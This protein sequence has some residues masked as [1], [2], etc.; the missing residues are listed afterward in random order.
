MIQ[1]RLQLLM[2]PDSRISIFS[3]AYLRY[4]NKKKNTKHNAPNRARVI[5]MM[6]QTGGLQDKKTHVYF[7]LN[8]SS[9]PLTEFV[10][11]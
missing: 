1:S 2:S 10:A 11:K 8:A 7:S 5:Q 3:L 9:H 6:R 4:W